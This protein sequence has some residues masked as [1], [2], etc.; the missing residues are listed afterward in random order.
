MLAVA[1]VMVGCSQE[2][3]AVVDNQ[4]VDNN[5]ANRPVVG[6]VEIGL[7]VESRMALKDGSALNLAYEVGDKVGAALIDV[8]KTTSV[9]GKTVGSTDYSG[10]S[11]NYD[12]YLV[13][14]NHGTSQ[15]PVYYTTAGLKSKDFY[16]TV[17]Y[18]SSNYPYT[19]NEDGS[20]ESEA[21]LL[22]GNYMFYMPY[23]AKHL[24]RKAIEVVLPQIQDCSDEV[25][26]ETTWKSNEKIEASSTVL[27]QFYAGT[28]EGFEGAPVLLGYKFLEAPKDGSLIKPSVDMNHLFAYPMITIKNDFNGFF[29]GSST[30]ATAATRATATM[31]VDSIQVYY[32]G[33]STNPLFYKK[34]V[35]S[36][37]IATELA[38]DGDWEEAKL[39]TGGLT[40]SVLG[41]ETT[42][43]FNHANVGTDVTKVANAQIA[44][45]TK[46]VTMVIGKELAYG[47]SYSFHSILPAGNYGDDLTAR[48]YVTIGSK[49]YVIINAENNVTYNAQGVA[50]RCDYV[51]DSKEDYTFVS[52]GGN[53]L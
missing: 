26:R 52:R 46:R 28:M 45:E 35:N 4:Q 48:V 25:M 15:N 40:A 41:D 3:L 17:E 2:E 53:G 22:E 7:G 50:T 34:P 12:E 6:N 13:N 36:A 44:P 43:T 49:R 11:W 21:N 1:A 47:D 29:Y 14:T 30:K 32:K 33:S 37:N 39:Q 19:R 38:T 16:S 8:A 9:A 23:N 31:I 18:I 42:A 51:T 5:L 24:N 10:Y 20:F 27:G